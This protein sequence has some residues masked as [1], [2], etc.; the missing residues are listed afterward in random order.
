LRKMG[1]PAHGHVV[2]DEL[3]RQFVNGSRRSSDGVEIKGF[4]A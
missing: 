4:A 3:Q 1:F 2:M